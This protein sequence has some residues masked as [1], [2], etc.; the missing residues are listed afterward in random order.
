MEMGE[1]MDDT[2]DKNY[3]ARAGILKGVRSVA[4][5]MYRK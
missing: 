1:N 4:W 3:R 5:R 2:V